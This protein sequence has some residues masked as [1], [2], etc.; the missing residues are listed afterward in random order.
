VTDKPIAGIDIAKDW[1]DICVDGAGVER[2]AN[3][4]EAVA[5]WLDRVGPRLVGFEPTGGHEQRLVAALRARD[6]PFLRVHPN[7]VI[8]FR[9][10]RGIKANSDRSERRS[11]L[12]AAAA[13]IRWYAGK[14]NGSAHPRPQKSSLLREQGLKRTAPF[15]C[16]C[17]LFPAVI[18]C[19]LL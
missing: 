15:R 16:S 3:S 2:I 13:V 5:A 6:V 7:D 18:R 11:R 4:A 10:S 17:S 14:Y 19:C 1:L 8:A 12:A 9:R